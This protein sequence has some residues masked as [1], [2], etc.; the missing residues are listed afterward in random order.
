MQQQDNKHR[1]RVIA[2]DDWWRGA[3]IYQIYPRSFADSNGDGVG[4][5]KGITARLKHVASL[6][7]DGIWLSPFF[8]SP[9][10][11]FG[12]DVADFCGVDPIFGSLEDFD[13]LLETAH[14]LGLKVIID[15]VYSHTSDQHAWFQASRE[16]RDSD[17]AD[18]YIWADARPDGTPPSNWQSVFMGPAWTFDSRRGQYYLHNFLSSQPDLNV[19]NPAVQKALLDTARFWLDRGVDGFRL[20]AVNFYM[21][22]P[23]FR[24]NPA[25]AGAKG[26]KPF[27]LQDHLYNQSHPDIPKFLERIRGLLDEYP[28]SFAVAE[29]GGERALEE[30]QLYT[31]GGKR[32]QTAYSFEFLEAD[33]LSAAVIRDAV[34]AWPQAAG[35]GWPSFTFS[36]HDRPRAVTRWARSE[37][38]E[39]DPRFAIFLNTLLCSLRGSICLYQGEEVGL[40]QGRVPFERLV[41]PEAIANWPDTLGRDGTRTPIPWLKG[42]PHAG[43][44]EAEPWLPVDERHHDFAIDAQEKDPKSPLHALRDFLAFR[45]KELALVKGSI[46]FLDTAE[47]VLAFVREHEGRKLL[48]VF[49]LGTEAAEW[50]EGNGMLLYSVNE[51]EPGKALPPISGYIAAL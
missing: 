42:V 7:V 17:K 51:A 27:D 23:E 34:A 5:L 25:L 48:C 1:T 38:E 50:A 43:F 30:M 45:H 16:G 12:Y 41:D 26:H 15:Q 37:S 21:H 11:D 46:S 35:T 19:H 39:L 28:E 3:V 9:M 20:D 4:D 49:N 32:L 13:E 33:T 29:V 22:D 40:P 31:E 24:D 44:S 8:T 18:W 10:K 36:N 14:R 47:P 6:G 2:G